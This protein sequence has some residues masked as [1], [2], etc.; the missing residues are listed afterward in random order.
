MARLTYRDAV[1][2][3]GAGN[4]SVVQALDKILGGLLLG[5]TPFVSGF[6]SIFDAKAELTKISNDLVSHGI[7][8][9]RKLTQFSRIQRLNAARGVLMVA[10]YFD[11]VCLAKLPFRLSEAKI[12]RKESVGVATS[13][14]DADTYPKLISAILSTKLPLLGVQVDSLRAREEYAAFYK[15]MSI[16]LVS[17]LEGLTIWDELNGIERT[18][19]VDLL[20]KAVPIEAVRQF[21]DSMQRL[22]TE[23]PEFAV[24][25]NIASHQATR[26]QLASIDD[27]VRTILARAEPV[28]H[29][30]ESLQ[31]IVRANREILSRKTAFY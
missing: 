1:N 13:T 12:S 10:A 29:V 2:I 15:K 3:L 26:D 20:L 16:R 11:A 14:S 19:T 4:S 28:A 9:R 22:A 21:D 31:A 18:Q 5:G 8:K 23:C 6:L 30:P 24:W 17:F 7:E 27:A 25:L